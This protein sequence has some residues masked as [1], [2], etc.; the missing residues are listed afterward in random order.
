MDT[1]TATSPLPPLV[2]GLPLVG[3]TPAMVKDLMAFVVEQYKRMG[4]IFRVRTFNQE[5]VIMAGPEA[6]IFVTQ[7]GIDKFSSR[8]TWYNFGQE[9]G[10]EDYIQDID[11]EPH[12][13]MRKM[14]KRGFSAG[15][16][17]SNV[18]LLVDIVQNV[19]DRFQ[20]GE[21]VATL[22]LLRLIV[23]EQLGRVLANHAPGDNLENIITSIKKALKVHVTKQMPM[24][25][26]RLP[27]YQWAKRRALQMGREII[28]EH[29][30]A[31]REKPDLVDDILALSQNHQSKDLLGS[32]A[33]LTF[34]AL[35]PFIAGL[36]TVANECTFML[37]ALLTH[38]DI[39]EQCVEEADYLFSDGVPK[40]TQLRSTGVLHHTVMETLRR[41]PIALAVYRTAAK[42]FE[43]AGYR[44]NKG[45][46]VLIASTASHF[47]PE[48][49]PDPYAFDIRRYS[50]PRKEHKKRGAYA[51]FGIGTHICLGAGAAEVQMVL[52]MASLLHMV[53]LEW[54]NPGAKL[55]MKNDPTPTFGHKFRVYIAERRH[56]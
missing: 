36:D 13:W 44:I 11:G 12:T 45:E 32:E 18:P 17:L 15:I 40:S 7:E 35:S 47:L 53:R 48:V 21:E 3:S 8:E 54:A 37:Y 55:R 56:Y 51:P 5:I 41:Y 1:I 38:P 33:Q 16:L 29:R 34:A 10:V 25:M 28:T 4:P 46:Q 42:T 19:I 2:P 9:F 20:V 27:S 24:F 22:Y 31:S 39:L 43:F 6:N 30:T 14:L 23:T 50:E 52:V 49:F 26:L